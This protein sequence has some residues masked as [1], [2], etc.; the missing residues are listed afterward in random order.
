MTFS[1]KAKSGNLFSLTWQSKIVK[2]LLYVK[3]N[4]FIKFSVEDTGV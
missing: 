3:T 4:L 2:V 1:A